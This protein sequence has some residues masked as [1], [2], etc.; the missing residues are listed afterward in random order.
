MENRRKKID[1]LVFALVIGNLLLFMLAKGTYDAAKGLTPGTPDYEAAKDLMYFWFDESNHMRYV[2]N[3]LIIIALLFLAR[4]STY[5]RVLMFIYLALSVKAAIL[6]PINGN[7]GTFIWDTVILIAG[8]LWLLKK[9]SADWGAKTC[10]IKEND[11]GAIYRVTTP[12][13]TFYSTILSIFG[14]DIES[15]RYYAYDTLYKFSK[16]TSTYGKANIAPNSV[17]GNIERINC[18]SRLFASCLNKKVGSNYRLFT[19]NCEN[20]TNE[21]KSKVGLKKRIFPQINTL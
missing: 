21:A 7:T 4:S 9:V 2:F 20:V 18:N 13:R 3:N 19:N 12:S 17:V 6:F 11:T 5:I 16:K 15:V 14:N 1:N 10:V 8:V